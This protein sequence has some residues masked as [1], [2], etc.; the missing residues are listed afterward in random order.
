VLTLLAVTV[1]V[2]VALQVEIMDVEL[3]VLFTLELEFGEVK[4]LFEI[5]V[6]VVLFLEDEEEEDVSLLEVDLV[7]DFDV[8]VDNG[9]EEVV[10][11]LLEVD[12]IVDFDVEVDDSLEEVDVR[13][14]LELDA[15]CAGGVHPPT[16]DG[17]AFGP[18]V[19]G[20]IFVPQFA[21]CARRTLELSWSYTTTHF[22]LDH[23]EWKGKIL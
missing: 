13:A 11:S 4:L 22:Q 5:I 3:G 21:A 20:T 12:I 23:Q 6:D 9:L 1:T 18:V 14:V 19:I 2:A 7:V 8:E 16:I 10:K 15:D 17:T